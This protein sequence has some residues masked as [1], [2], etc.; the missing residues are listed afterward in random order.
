MKRLPAAALL[1][2]AVLPLEAQVPAPDLEESAEVAHRA[3]AAALRGQNRVLFEALNIDRILERRLGGEVWERLTPRQ[4]EPL[5]E[6]VRQTFGAAL[7]PARSTPGEIAWSSAR[8][9]APGVAVL[10]G[11]RYGDRWVKTRWSL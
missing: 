10:L 4:R 8:E 11:I 1:L 3:A 6:M 9:E 5:R 2:A 7:S